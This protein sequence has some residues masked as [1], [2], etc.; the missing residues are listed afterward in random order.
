MVKV[1]PAANVPPIWSDPLVK[2]PV[3]KVTLPRLPVVRPPP[4]RPFTTVKTDPESD[5]PALLPLRVP[6]ELL[7]S[8]L[9]LA[10]AA[11]DSE[12]TRVKSRVTFVTDI[13]APLVTC[14]RV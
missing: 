3:E 12:M 1:P 5:N 2:A 7:K 9:L 10:D 11:S 6:P 13:L 14:Q 8:T 4:L